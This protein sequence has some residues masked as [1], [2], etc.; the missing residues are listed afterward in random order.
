MLPNYSFKVL[1]KGASMVMAQFSSQVKN[2]MS[3]LLQK[4]VDSNRDKKL[5]FAFQS[6][7]HLEIVICFS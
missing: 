7:L 6:T 2:A 4:F 1:Y 5:T 3:V